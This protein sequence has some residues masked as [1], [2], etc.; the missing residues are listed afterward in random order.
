MWGIRNLNNKC[1]FTLYIPS[2]YTL[3]AKSHQTIQG[4]VAMAMRHVTANA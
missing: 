1:L 3:L 4:T 2:I